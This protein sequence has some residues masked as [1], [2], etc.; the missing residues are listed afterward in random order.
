MDRFIKDTGAYT[1]WQLSDNNLYELAEF[2]VW[3]NYKHHTNGQMSTTSIS[4]IACIHQEEMKYFN[5]SRIFVARNAE[6]K[7]IGTIRLMHWDGY[8]MLP[9]QTLFN[10]RSLT[11]ISPSDS[12][13][14]IWHIGRFAVSTDAGHNGILLFK[15]LLLYAIAPM[16]EFDKGIVF[17]ECDSRLLRTMRLMGI[18]A[19]S[20]GRGIEYLGS[21]TIP[22]YATLNGIGGFFKKNRSLLSNPFC[23]SA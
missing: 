8:E 22:I 21:E 1:I 18:E 10:I 3:E 5:R 4:E 9:I 20:L 19:E 7:I 11:D 6:N 17:A 13:T 12:N 2:V 14:A 16:F 23:L 15:L